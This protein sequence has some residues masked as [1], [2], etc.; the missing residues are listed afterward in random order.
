MFIVLFLISILE[1]EF[2]SN[3]N[4]IQCTCLN[5][6]QIQLNCNMQIHSILNH[7]NGA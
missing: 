1:F 7:S 5:P 2:K 6:N 3:M 4:F